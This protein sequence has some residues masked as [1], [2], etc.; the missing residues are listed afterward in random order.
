MRVFNKYEPIGNVHMQK[1]IIGNKL[2]T[3]V[4]LFEDS[5]RKSSLTYTMEFPIELVES[6]VEELY[7]IGYEEVIT[8]ESW[9]QS[10]AAAVS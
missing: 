7:Q 3:E 1:E 6:L 4:Y 8:R 10:K 5:K 2:V 9:R